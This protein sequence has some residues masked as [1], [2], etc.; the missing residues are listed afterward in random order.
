MILTDA[1]V[2]AGLDAL[3]RLDPRLAPVV[4]GAGPVPLR[5]AEPGLAGLVATVVAQQVSRASASAIL[6]RLREAVEI[7]RAAAIL[8]AEDEVLRRAGL[9][10]AKIRTLRAAA[11]A[12]S[13]GRL[14]FARIER[15]EPAAAVSELVA[16]P[17]IG[18]WTAECF[19]LFSLGHPDVF[20]AG[21][22]ALRLAVADGLALSDARPKEA[23]VAEIARV[24]S[25][26]RSVAARL[27]WRHYHVVT[28]RDAAPAT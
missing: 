9:S 12:M 14:D 5:R 24:W 4:E 21:D 2:A 15:A 16:L 19:L 27:F 26:H 28:R 17:G 1:D 25:P 18:L 22:L 7:S 20:P 6:G 10:A 3:V 8:D 13:E 23:S 11:L